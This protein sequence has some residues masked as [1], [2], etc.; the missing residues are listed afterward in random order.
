[1]QRHYEW[2]LERV[3]SAGVAGNRRARSRGGTLRVVTTRPHRNTGA[4]S[5]ARNGF[6]SQDSSVRLNKSC[7]TAAHLSCRLRCP[8]GHCFVVDRGATESR[9]QSPLSFILFPFS[10]DPATFFFYNCTFL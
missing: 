7:A 5:K 3:A 4:N 1:M 9:A 2:R 6:Y 10:E 8:V